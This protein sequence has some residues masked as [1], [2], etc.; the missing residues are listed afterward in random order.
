LPVD[1]SESQIR[2]KLKTM[3]HP[4]HTS[5]QR[6]VRY[7]KERSWVQPFNPFQSL[8]MDHTTSN[9]IAH[10]RTIMITPQY[11]G[12]SISPYVND[13]YCISSPI[14]KRII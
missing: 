10:I 14:S 7:A 6:N 1:F 5:M 9:K 4:N 11:T 3:A 2:I 12:A 13:A 8:C